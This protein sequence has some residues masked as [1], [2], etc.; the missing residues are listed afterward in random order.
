[1][2]VRW[3]LFAVLIFAVNFGWEMAQGGLF[4]NMQALPFWTATRRCFIAAAGDVVIT[5][6]AFALAAA[7]SRQLEWPLMRQGLA[8]S[9]A[10]FLVT[11]LGITI[12]FERWALASGR[13]Q[14]DARMPV[15][16]GLGVTPLLQWTI[17]PLLA[18][19]LFRLIWNAPRSRR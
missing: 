8:P 12:L 16:F 5:A 3:I 15:V 18:L 2:M 10:T 19:P 4:A 17:I 6:I 11:A 9:T 1:M 7:V 13:W 14:Y